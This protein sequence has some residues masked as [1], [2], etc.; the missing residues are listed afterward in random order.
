MTKIKMGFV[1]LA[2][3]VT[4]PLAALAAEG[5]LRTTGPT[6]AK[7]LPVVKQL[8]QVVK[9]QEQRDEA[10]VKRGVRVADYEKRAT[11]TISNLLA[12]LDELA[13]KADTYLVKLEGQGGNTTDARAQQAK[14]VTALTAAKEALAALSSTLPTPASVDKLTTKET[15]A[16]REAVLKVV[17][18]A[19]TA[20]QEFVKLVQLIRKAF[21]LVNTP[22]TNANQ[23]KEKGSVKPESVQ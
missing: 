6:T 3:V 12:K 21:T 4:M 2:L 1:G 15:K 19:R 10:Q 5:Q 13:T 20:N 9:V 18:D 23:E 16:T 7:P 22:D 8:D 14:F 11:D 17:K